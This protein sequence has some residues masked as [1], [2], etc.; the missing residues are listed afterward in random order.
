M[1]K[2]SLLGIIVPLLTLVACGT[3]Q[4]EDVK[5]STIEQNY[6][7]DYNQGHKLLTA[8]AGYA[9]ENTLGTSLKLTGASQV[10]FN[11][12]N[13]RYNN[14]L[15]SASYGTELDLDQTPTK[16]FEFRY[17]N[18]DGEIFSIPTH[19]PPM[20]TIQYPLE[21]AHVS[22]TAELAVRLQGEVLKGESLHLCL[23]N[24]RSS[25]EECLYTESSM[26]LVFSREQL[27]KFNRQESLSL[28]VERETHPAQNNPRIHLTE[29]FVAKPLTLILD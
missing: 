16:L 6:T 14:I 5:Q 3:G 10:T 15:N 22:A 19:V 29:K 4:S 23:V 9:Y 26:N 7:L 28:E 8:A 12:T 20:T 21:G 18:N 13:M 1:A 17:V 24:H 11:G 2:K 27:A 25:Q